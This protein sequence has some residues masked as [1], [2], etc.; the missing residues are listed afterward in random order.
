[1]LFEQPPEMTASDTEPR[2]QSLDA[3]F[4]ERAFTYEIERAPDGIRRSPPPR[5]PG[6]DFGTAPQT[7]PEPG[8]VRGGSAAVER[9]VLKFRCA[10]GTSGTAKDP[11]AENSRVETPIEPRVARFER[12]V[13]SFS[14][15]LD[16]IHAPIMRTPGPKTSRFRTSSRARLFR[17]FAVDRARFV[18]LGVDV[19]F[20]F[21]R[22]PA[23]PGNGHVLKL[24][25][26]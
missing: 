26:P 8:S 22:A 15:E 12:L 11:R 13:A 14:V 19:I 23:G 5:E 2:R 16:V 1:M 6:R 4:G 9:A 7:G 25:D 10:R 18:E 20:L 3:A 17:E 24:V 21:L